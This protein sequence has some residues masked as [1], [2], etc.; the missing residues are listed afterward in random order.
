MSAYR[1][2]IEA[3]RKDRVE[4]LTGKDGWLT[5]V[6]LFWLEPGANSFGRA[7]S[8]D[9]S[10]DNSN[11]PARAGTFLLEK[12]EVRFQAARDT[13]IT[14]QGQAVESIVMSPDSSGDPAILEVGRLSFFI[15]EREG[16]LGVRLK[17][18]QAPAR[19]NFTGL[20]YF[21]V[22][23][24]WRVQ[25]DFVP[26]DP[27]KKVPIANVLGLATE[28]ESPGALTFELDGR[29]YRLDPVKEQGDELFIM[30][31]DETTGKE[32]YGAGRYLYVPYPNE[33]KVL[34]DFNK[35]YNPPCVFSEYATCPL[36]PVQNRL[37]LRVE[38][39]E[40]TYGHGH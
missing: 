40:K 23:L 16:R 13:T 9:I 34:M 24:K 30:F 25:A 20:E 29:E 8:N 12:G 6:G 3:Y 38:A 19:L 4:R 2:E 26:Y 27:P 37:E 15:I 22:D 28:M 18:S 31:A 5:L 14:H 7:D 35:A 21:P 33:G 32:T 36:P 11:L 1:A 39:G 10:L 17:D